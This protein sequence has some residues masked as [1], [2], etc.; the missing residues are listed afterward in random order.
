MLEI[1]QYFHGTCIHRQPGMSGYHEKTQSTAHV[2][3]LTSVRF[4]LLI[5]IIKNRML[6]RSLGLASNYILCTNAIFFKIGLSLND[7]C[8]FCDSSK[9]ELYHLFF[10]C[11]HAQIFWK[12][13]SSRWFKLVKENITVTLTLTLAQF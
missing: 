9:E 6:P 8:T 1:D 13:F 10:E 5:A 11:S 4:C 12:K 7:K 3:N 2:F